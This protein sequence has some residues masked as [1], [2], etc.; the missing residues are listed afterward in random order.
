MSTM[1]A[2]LALKH[3]PRRHASNR[4]PVALL[5]EARVE[6]ASHR[7]HTG[8]AMLVGGLHDL[9][10]EMAPGE[11]RAFA[12]EVCPE[13]PV[14]WLVHED[15]FVRR[16]YERPRG[17]PGDAGT[18]DLIYGAV[19]LPAETTELGRRLYFENT[20]AGACQSVRW[21]RD[22]LAQHIDRAAA[23]HPSPRVLALACGH[24]REAERSRA[25]AEGRVGAFVAVD[26]DAE[27][28]ALLEREQVGRGVTARVGTV[29]Q[30]LTGRLA[31]EGMDLVYA[32]GLYDYLD[33]ATAA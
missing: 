26:Q 12:T 11:W 10:S 13:H 2:T 23:E 27:C 17:Y 1:P 15:P 4:R 6:L 16:A 30:A 14:R 19:P 32:A 5:D 29:R 31:C 7:V 25:V 33:A 9:R 21:R 3:A 8:M 22:V 18:L 28:I 24:L 20:G